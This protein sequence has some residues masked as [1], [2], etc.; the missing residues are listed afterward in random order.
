[1]ETVRLRNKIGSLEKY[2]SDT[3]LPKIKEFWQNRDEIRN[4]Y[5]KQ[6]ELEGKLCSKNCVL[7]TILWS[8]QKKLKYN[9]CGH[10]LMLTMFHHAGKEEDP[11]ENLKCENS[12]QLFLKSGVVEE[13]QSEEFDWSGGDESTKQNKIQ[14]A[15]NTIEN[16]V[17]DVVYLV[18]M[19]IPDAMGGGHAIACEVSTENERKIAL[20]ADLQNEWEKQFGCS[21]FKAYLEDER[22]V[23]VKF[24]I[25]KE[26]KLDEIIL[27]YWP[28]MHHTDGKFQAKICLPEKMV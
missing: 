4:E 2:I 1:M 16:T 12:I 21:E 26:K 22:I 17:G 18:G 6:L 28:I 11:I 7:C 5:R 19:K 25:I 10:Q 14:K 13:L 24:Y 9:F 20:F 15:L 23:G 27:K 3:L 8:C